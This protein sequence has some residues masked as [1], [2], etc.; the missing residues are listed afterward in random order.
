MS[1]RTITIT[2]LSSIAVFVAWKL[3]AKNKETVRVQKALE[4]IISEYLEQ[5]K[6]HPDK[7][8]SLT[9]KCRKS[10][11]ELENENKQA[12]NFVCNVFGYPPNNKLGTL[13]LKMLNVWND[14]A[15][16]GVCDKIAEYT[17]NS[18]TKLK[19]CELGPGA[20]RSIEKMFKKFFF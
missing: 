14:I 5:L 12:L 7:Q 16:D 20:G 6:I 9:Q 3:N 11:V 2:A 1:N 4:T 8:K 10:I 15:F 19:I 13:M 18:T 17:K